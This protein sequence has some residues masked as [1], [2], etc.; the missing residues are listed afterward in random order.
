MHNNPFGD[1]KYLNN[2]FVG[3]G[4]LS[5]YDKAPLPVKMDGNVF[6]N[7]AKPSRHER[8]PVVNKAFDPGLKLEEKDGAFIL[9]MTL[10]GVLGR[11]PRRLVTSELLGKAV[12][13]GLPY[14]QA[15]GAPV[16]IDADYFGQARSAG[17][18]TP[19]PFEAPGPGA[20]RLTVGRLTS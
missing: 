20:L 18:P 13:P 14:E 6:L 9:Q 2:L 16:R 17:N 12:I 3:P 7:G 10:A 11:G 19:G 8:R 1:D 5:V 4:D 15:D